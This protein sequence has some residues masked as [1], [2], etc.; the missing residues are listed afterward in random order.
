[1]VPVEL[2]LQNFLSYGNAPPRLDFE[3]FHVAC[4]S[5]RNGQGKSALLDAITWALWG[6]ARKSSDSRKPD[7]ELIRIGSRHMEVELVFDIEGRR[8][9]VVRS[10]SRTATGKSTKPGLE[11]NILEADAGEYRPLTGAS[12]RD[13]QHQLD[14]LLGLDYQTFINSAF[15][16]QGRSDEFTKK[17]PTERKQIL[18]RILN[19]SKFD[20]L[21]DLAR[22][23]ERIAADR[24]V[25][26]EREIE[27]LQ[28]ALAD[29]PVW[30]EN[31]ER[32]KGE[33][34]EIQEALER[35]RA[36]ED[37]LKEQTA[38]L[39]ARAL[40]AA[41]IQ[42]NLRSLEKRTAEDEATLQSLQQRILAAEGLLAR[43][44]QIL[45]D[46]ERAEE[47]RKEHEKLA[48]AQH[49][50]LGFHNQ[51]TKQQ[52]ALK[53]RKND[54][55]KRLHNLEV[56]V[57]RD[58]QDQTEC[59]TQLVE[60]SSVERQLARARAARTALQAQ[61]EVRLRRAG[62]EKEVELL[63]KTL[64]GLHESLLG[65]RRALEG[66]IRQDEGTV[67]ARHELHVQAGKL[68]EQQHALEALQERLE[69]TRGQ[70]QQV[71]EA[72][73]EKQGLLS[74]NEADLAK[75][76]AAFARFQALTEGACPTCGTALTPAHRVEVAQEFRKTMAELRAR[77]R[78]VEAEI[79]QAT[80][81]R[82]QLR[83]AYRSLHAEVE[84]LKGVPAEKAAVLEAQRHAEEA[85]TALAQ[86]KEALATLVRQLEAQAYGVRERELLVARKRQLAED[87]FDEKAYEDLRNQAAQV[88]RYEER[89]QALALVAGRKEQLDR[90]LALREPQVLV[91]RTQLADESVFSSIREEISNLEQQKV[92]TG[93]DPQR[94]EEVRANL[95]QLGDAGARMKDL[96][97]AQQN[98]EA[99]RTERDR[100]G[101]RIG[102]ARMERDGLIEKI[103]AIEGVLKERQGLQV[104]L[105]E[106]TKAR[107]M[108]EG[109]QRTLQVQS[110]EVT[111]RLEQ[112]RKDRTAL[113]QHR[114][115]KR[116]AQEERTLNRH[117]KTAFG[118]HGI[119]SLIIEHT[120]PDI[121]D[122]ANELLARLTDGRMHV[123]LETL[124]D[125]KKGGTKETLD[126]I[127]SDEQGVARA[128][129]T[130]SGGEAFRVNFA[131]RIA[132]AQLLAERS[133]VR[134]RTLVID[135]GFGTQDTQ[136]VENL[137]EA[138][139]AIQND[140]E[141]IVV[142]THLDQLKDAFPIRIEVTKDS[143]E[144]SSFEVLGV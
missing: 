12:I 28:A 41:A 23:R 49:L 128:Y 113:K 79:K 27:R 9:R 102:Q 99:W 56:E 123:R 101:Q 98:Q 19:L 34:H 42:D 89:R 78:G 84:A 112:A 97:N 85:A 126:I 122:R 117:L 37:T 119:P 94:L 131:L 15:L 142:I 5:G 132:L 33:L 108:K 138:I 93:F 2:R 111:A 71:G 39:E 21:A 139:Q 16:L 59:E 107:Q 26:A 105:N 13:T 103:K 3:Q 82:D 1:M 53:D 137:V 63:E 51:I 62:W 110:G 143:V 18:T 36:E 87:P 133:G 81:H 75:Q 72:L 7:E 118:K 135:E 104:A 20:Q 92:R 60:V 134:V 116:E 57:K 90:A 130:Y 10:F 4:L 120:L 46:Y 121:E 66:Q 44:D 17:K 22:E 43:N 140:F 11:L 95:K 29:E 25:L 31:H 88:D 58:R 124:K 100:I 35:V 69:Q 129:E 86:K 114:G 50:Y 74:A 73:K 109:A 47:L 6:E 65:Q 127:I 30:K 76:E 55:E 106:K 61:Q 80:E 115:E 54:L 24:V 67:A 52:A 144:G 141:K 38:A 8:Y 136:G 77:M 70:G 68:T 125:L 64:H 91:L 32:I 96:L 45:K 14:A 83:E 40:E 48:E